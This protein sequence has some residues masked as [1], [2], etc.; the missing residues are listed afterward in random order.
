MTLERKD[1]VLI[2]KYR[3]S[4]EEEIDVKLAQELGLSDFS[5]HLNFFKQKLSTKNPEQIKAFNKLF[6]NGHSANE[7]ISKEKEA[8]S[9]QLDSDNDDS[10]TVESRPF[11]AKK[12]FKQIVI[13]T[14]PDKVS[15]LSIDVLIEKLTRHYMLATESYA[16]C[17]YHNLIMIAFDLDISFDHGLIVKEILPALQ[18]SQKFIA[19]EKTKLGYQWYN[20][21][22][23]NKRETLKEFLLGRGFT[24]SEDDITDAISHARQKSKRKAGSRPVKIKRQRLK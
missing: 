14:H 1:R 8:Q 3:L 22:S 13:A 16:N 11:W 6:F 5:N 7:G 2:L 15:N 18:S 17:D 19:I 9:E 23:D 4:F 20:L 12:L 10:F 24:F 21:H